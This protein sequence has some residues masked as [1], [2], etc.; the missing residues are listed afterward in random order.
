MEKQIIL[1]QS[2]EEFTMNVRG[3][4]PGCQKE[5]NPLIIFLNLEQFILRA[6]DITAM[7]KRR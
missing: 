5:K 1:L 7:N 6:G 4:K 2:T 3:Y